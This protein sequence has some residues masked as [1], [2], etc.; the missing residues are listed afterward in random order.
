MGKKYIHEDGLTKICSD[1]FTPGEMYA[2]VPMLRVGTRK[3]A[4]LNTDTI[5]LLHFNVLVL[6]ASRSIILLPHSRNK[7][8]VGSRLLP[9]AVSAYSTLGG[10]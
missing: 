1:E 7:S 9:N 5:G 2:L 10:T 8:K 3:V 6:S 4:I